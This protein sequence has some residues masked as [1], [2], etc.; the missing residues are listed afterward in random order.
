L[1]CCGVVVAGRIGVPVLFMGLRSQRVAR[2]D[3]DWVGNL[4][5]SVSYTELHPARWAGN[6]DAAM[7]IGQRIGDRVHPHY[8][9]TSDTAGTLW[10]L[11]PHTGS[12]ACVELAEEPPYIVRQAGSRQL[13]D[14]VA[15]AY[16]WWRTAGEPSVADWIVTV[17]PDGQR[18]QLV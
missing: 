2:P 17:T 1:W 11:E 13:F 6:R 9:P 15:E 4:P 14:E 5:G 16:H 7:A 3:N 10:L 12:W 8:A 18:I